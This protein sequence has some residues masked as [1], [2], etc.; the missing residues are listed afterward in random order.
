MTAILGIILL[1]LILFVL[2]LG[3]NNIR[4]ELEKIH[5]AQL[6]PR[7]RVGSARPT[8]AEPRQGERSYTPPNVGRVQA[9]RTVVGG[10]PDSEL[11]QQL[12]QSA[13][14]DNDE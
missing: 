2:V 6:N 3:L 1:A 8:P 11:N 13:K 12:S 9:R 7:T 14:R 5:E 10:E 4:D